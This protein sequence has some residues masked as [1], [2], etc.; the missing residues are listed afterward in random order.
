MIISITGKAGSGKSTIAQRLADAL[1]YKRY[2]IGGLRR[3]MAAERGMT[4]EELNTL[5]EREDWTDREVDE[6]AERL[7]KSEDNFV[8]EGRTMF[9]FIPSSVKIFLDVSEEE[10]ARRIYSHLKDG[11]GADRNEARDLDSVEAVLAANRKRIASD[12]VRYQ[13]YYG[14]ENVYDPKHFD[15]WLDTTKLTPDEVFDQVLIF[16]RSRSA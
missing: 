13:K 10:G 12:I 9:H 14:I 7:G 4:L 2:Y 8:I 11:G 3:K 5:G 6:Y 16:V 1:Q 15:L